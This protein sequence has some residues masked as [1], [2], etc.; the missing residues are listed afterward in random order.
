MSGN[1]S[2]LRR[3]HLPLCGPFSKMG[4]PTDWW[5]K[6]QGSLISSTLLCYQCTNKT[7]HLLCGLIW[8][9]PFFSLPSEYA[10][11]LRAVN[12]SWRKLICTQLQFISLLGEVH[13]TPI[14]SW[15]GRL[16]HSGIWWALSLPVS[17]GEGCLGALGIMISMALQ[18][19][20]SL[21]GVH[22]MWTLSQVTQQGHQTFIDHSQKQDR[23]KTSYSFFF[24]PY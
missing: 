11:N 20:Y 13:L 2:T 23:W 1:P 8:Q 9:L 7:F 19:G 17:E 12:S 14:P 5:Q 18:L 22:F 6:H 4:S 21:Q 24:F 3:V 10:A 15:N 16:E